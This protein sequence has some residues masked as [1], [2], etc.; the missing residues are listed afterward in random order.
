MQIVPLASR[1]LVRRVV[2][3]S[4]KIGGVILPT[5]HSARIG[6][7]LAV[8]PGSHSAGTFVPTTLAAG[9]R[10]L[11]PEFGGVPVEGPDVLLFKEDDIL[12]RV[13]PE[14]AHLRSLMQ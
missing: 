7:V 14:E 11:L 10:V 1:V 8:G 12:A 13:N 2:A 9:D 5:S 3:E 6:E 4:Q